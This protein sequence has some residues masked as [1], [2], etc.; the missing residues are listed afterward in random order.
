MKRRQAL[1]FFALCL[2][3]SAE[4]LTVGL[5]P[6]QL[7]LELGQGL[8][9]LLIGMLALIFQAVRRGDGFWTPARMVSLAAVGAGTIAVPLVLLDASQ[10]MS[11]AVPSVIVFSL[12]PVLVIVANGELFLLIPALAGVGGVLLLVPSQLP[13]STNG[14]EGLGLTVTAAALT[15]CGLL[16]LPRLLK[17]V[18]T[19]MAIAAISLSSGLLLSALGLVRGGASWGWG[20]IVF[21]ILRGLLLDVPELV[22]LLWLLKKVAP[23]RVAAR[24]LIA[25]L[26]TVIEGYLVLRPRLD[27]RTI[28]GVILLAAGGWRL[29]TAEADEGP[30]LRL[31]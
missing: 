7:P 29:L 5:L 30:A 22:L 2:W 28:A 21:E 15:G 14:W 1:A 13:G 26:L 8:H 9:F 20:V 17:G 6:A 18:T 19:A 31:F 11:V 4:W 16:L 25:P 23:Y 24:F 3:S 27:T 10:A 12:V